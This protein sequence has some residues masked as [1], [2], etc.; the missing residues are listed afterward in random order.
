MIAVDDALLADEESSQWLYRFERR[1]FPR[2]RLILSLASRSPG[3]A[4]RPVEQIVSEPSARVMALGPLAEESVGALAAD[5]FGAPAEDAFVRAC[6]AETGGYPGLLLALFRELA[7]ARQS[8]TAVAVERVH[9]VTSAAV[10]R[11]ALGKLA[12]LGP[13]AKAV[14]DAVA[15]AGA[16]VDLD[17]VAEVT[18]LEPAAASRATDGLTAVDLLVHGRPLAFRH[19][20]VR[21]TVYGELTPAS[22]A[23]LHIA[24][25][26]GMKARGAP[27]HQLAEHLAAAEPSGDEWVATQLEEAGT[28]ALREGASA[29]AVRYLSRAL[30]EQP[31]APRR[32]EM[33]LNLARAEASLDVRP[34]LAYLRQSLEQGADPGLAAHAALEVCGRT[35]DLAAR[36]DLGPMLQKIAALVSDEDV[37]TKIELLVSA[38]IVSRSPAETAQAAGLLRQLVGASGDPADSDRARGGRAPGGDRVG[39]PYARPARRRRDRR[40]AGCAR[41]RA[42]QPESDAM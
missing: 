35:P 17:L 8:P 12:T 22:R 29:Q 40:V 25:A 34:A 39:Q 11:A 41:R 14:I 32:P 16:P 30:A 10:A 36:A 7:L 42:G 23:R 19:P 33:L 38:V 20:F 4:L 28:F 37:S 2:T 1:G 6:I 27:V 24:M 3:S 26:K 13:E 9:T 21:R 5:Y 31:L 15:V 18:G